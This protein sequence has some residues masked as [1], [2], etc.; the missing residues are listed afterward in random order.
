MR[1]EGID[2]DQLVRLVCRCPSVRSVILHRLL[3]L[4][5]GCELP[6]ICATTATQ[7][8]IEVQFSLLITR[9]FRSQSLILLL[10]LHRHLQVVDSVAVEAKGLKKVL[11]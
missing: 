11:Q 4:Q 6:M 1:Y 10:Y 8:M 9:R 7:K 2:L 5:R 3:L